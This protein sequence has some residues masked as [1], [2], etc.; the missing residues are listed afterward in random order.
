M[1]REIG[2]AFPPF[3]FTGLLSLLG[4]A[5]SVPFSKEIVDSVLQFG[6]LG[7]CGYMVFCNIRYQNS[8]IDQHRIEREKLVASLERTANTYERLLERTV[9]MMNR[10]TDTLD[11][12]PCLHKDPRLNAES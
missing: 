10:I 9:T 7:L 12:R 11:D 8:L 1:L 6:A 2:L 4:S 3:I 5:T